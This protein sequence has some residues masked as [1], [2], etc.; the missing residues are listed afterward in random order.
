MTAERWAD[1]CA[2]TCRERRSRWTERLAGVWRGLEELTESG[3]G[4]GSL[5]SGS[6]AA[7]FV[8]VQGRD[9][10]LQAAREMAAAT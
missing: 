2:T 9:E 1:H 3:E 10:A 8:V 6:G 7:F 5:L 4:E